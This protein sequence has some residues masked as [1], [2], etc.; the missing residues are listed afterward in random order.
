MRLTSLNSKWRRRYDDKRLRV[1]WA[2][3]GLLLH[4][5]AYLGAIK[6]LLPM[7]FDAPPTFLNLLW[8][9]ALMA[10]FVIL[11]ASA[12]VVWAGLFMGR[13]ASRKLSRTVSPPAEVVPWGSHEGLAAQQLLHRIRWAEK[14]FSDADGGAEEAWEQ[15]RLW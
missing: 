7:F 5:L 2:A 10:V 8:V 12:L 14:N 13:R 3:F 4:S 9:L 1:Q 11:E 6:L 15:V